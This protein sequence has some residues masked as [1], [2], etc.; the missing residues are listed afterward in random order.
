MI[1]RPIVLDEEIGFSKKKFIVSKTD[2]EGN[3]LFVNQNFC[4]ITGYEYEELMGQ[5][6]SVLRH[7]D[8]PEAIFYMIWKSLFAGM[9][10]SAIIKNVAKSGAYYWVIADFS[11]QRNNYGELETFTSFKRAAPAT[12]TEEVAL[13]YQEMISSERRGGVEASLQYL[14][15]FLEERQMSYNEYLEDLVKAKGI[16]SSLLKKVNK[17]FS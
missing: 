10:V 7:P 17:V 1:Y 13:L 8:M 2:L 12:V 14:E 6:H 16:F 4:D 3:I 11:M 15:I 5:S 9:E